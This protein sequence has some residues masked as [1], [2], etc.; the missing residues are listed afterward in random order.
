MSKDAYYFPHDS[1]ARHDPKIIAMTSV[2][3]M[4]GYAWYW[5]IVEMLREQE[6]YRYSFKGKYAIN[7]M[8]KEMDTDSEKANRFLEDCV[9]EF[10]LLEIEDDMLSCPSLDKR[11]VR[12]DRRRSQAKSAANVRWSKKQPKESD[13]LDFTNEEVSEDKVNP[14]KIKNME[15][16]TNSIYFAFFSSELIQSEDFGDMKNIDIF[17]AKERDIAVDWMRS[18]G[19]KYKDYRAMFRNWIRRKLTEI[20][21]PKEDVKSNNPQLNNPYEK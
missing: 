11:M 15:V 10:E 7:S 21:N 3:G 18:K 1:N 20:S 2:Y 9:K 17:L 5:V 6:G 12:L 4:V 8:A 16:L 13:D 19:R 14:E